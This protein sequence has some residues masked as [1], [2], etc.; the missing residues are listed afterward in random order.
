MPPKKRSL[1]FTLLVVG[2]GDSE[3]AFLKHLRSL[4]CTNQEGVSVTVMNAH[5]KGPG[6]VISTAIGH[7][8][9]RQFDKA[10]A[11]LDTDLVWVKKD[12][13]AARKAGIVLVGSSPCLEGLLLQILGR[14]VPEASAHCKG[15]VGKIGAGD[16][17]D[18]SAYTDLWP[19]HVLEQARRTISKLDLLL[20]HFEGEA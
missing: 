10:L 5:G 18:V 15:A 20:Q 4:Y 9:N 17:T 1:R 19:K 14:P 8:R 3:V 11:M 16:I 6:N 12:I 7:R 2:E 13:E